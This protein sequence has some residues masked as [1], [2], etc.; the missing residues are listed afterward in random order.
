[1]I[2]GAPPHTQ[3]HRKFLI[4]EL[5]CKFGMKR[6]YLENYKIFKL[7]YSASVCLIVIFPIKVIA[8][9]MIILCHRL[10]MIKKFQVV[11]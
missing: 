7:F 5:H 6:P 3:G 11:S 10:L 8:A 1:M 2:K 9:Q 4:C